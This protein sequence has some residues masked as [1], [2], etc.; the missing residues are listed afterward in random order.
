MFECEWTGLLMF[1]GVSHGD[2]A[3]EAE[4][5]EHQL[6]YAELNR[7]LLRHLTAR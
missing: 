6:T 2:C 5:P 7:F 1:E 3:L 4:S